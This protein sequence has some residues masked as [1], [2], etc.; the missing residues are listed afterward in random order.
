MKRHTRAHVRE[1]R[2]RWIWKRLRQIRREWPVWHEQSDVPNRAHLPGKLNKKD[3]WDCGNTQCG[4]CRNDGITRR[5]LRE[6][7]VVD[8]ELRELDE[9]R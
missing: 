3:P 7:A 8:W 5:Y 6:R 1:R 9:T 4:L 2:S